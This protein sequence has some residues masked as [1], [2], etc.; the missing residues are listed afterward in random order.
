MGR[1]LFSPRQLSVMAPRVEVFRELW[2]KE[3]A[4]GDSERGD[5]GGIRISRA[6]RWTSFVDYNSRMTRWHVRAKWW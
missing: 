3:N 1:D 2:A 4:K 5:A 6:A